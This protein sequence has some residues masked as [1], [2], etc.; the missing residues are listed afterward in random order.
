MEKLRN[1]KPI[2]NFLTFTDLASGFMLRETMLI[3]EQNSQ[4]TYKA[5]TNRCKWR[6]QT[7]KYFSL[8]SEETMK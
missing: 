3:I 5:K 7:L 6:T 2:V 8:F 4:A 1:I